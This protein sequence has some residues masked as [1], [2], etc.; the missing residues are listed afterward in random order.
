MPPKPATAGNTKVAQVDPNKAGKFNVKLGTSFQ[1][2]QGLTTIR[3]NKKPD[4]VLDNCTDSETPP[5]IKRTGRDGEN[6]ELTLQGTDGEKIYYTGQQTD[7]QSF[8][9]LFVFDPS[10][11]EFTVEQLDSNFIMNMDG[12]PAI[13]VDGSD[14]SS[15]ENFSD[16]EPDNPY[17]FRRFVIK[18]PKKPKAPKE[19]RKKEEEERGFSLDSRPVKVT[20]KPSPMKKAT[21][22]KE[23]ATKKITKPRKA[24]VKKTAAPKKSAITMPSQVQARDSP[25]PMSL[26]YSSKPAT[27]KPKPTVAK[28]TNGGPVSLKAASNLNAESSESDADNESSEDE[29]GF[30]DALIVENM[31]DGS[32]R[33]GGLFGNRNGLSVGNGPI[34]LSAASQ[35]P[36]ALGGRRD[37]SESEESE[38]DDGRGVTSHPIYRPV[39]RQQQEEEESDADED[40][41]DRFRMPVPSPGAPENQDDDNEEDFDLEQ[42]M[43]DAF[44]EVD[45]A[46]QGGPI[47]LS[48]MTGNK[49]D[50]SSSEEE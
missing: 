50:E 11:Q 46:S 26:D 33:G 43:L 29:G 40:E 21:E 48:A 9:V 47:S 5:V 36:M 39:I 25:G 12:H 7:A 19:E 23:A 10:T 14:D 41:D 35:S 1:T 37:E 28:V 2:G 30:V 31:D 20:P 27:P 38:E 42:E 18:T 24:P 8:E 3:Y 45:D 6:V 22:P 16:P 13:G 44:S 15:D 32:G 17:D 4:S 49:L 34:S